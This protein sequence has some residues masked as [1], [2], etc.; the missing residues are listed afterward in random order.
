MTT[1]T[2]TK[3]LTIP[4]REV[5]PGD[6]LFGMT[7]TT[8]KVSSTADELWFIGTESK[9]LWLAPR[10]CFTVERPVPSDPIGTVRAQNEQ[11]IQGRE[12]RVGDEVDYL[13]EWRK[14]AGTGASSLDGAVQIRFEGH[15]LFVYITE[16]GYHDVRRPQTAADLPVGRILR[17]IL[18][19]YYLVKIAENT[20]AQFFS[21]GGLCPRKYSDGDLGTVFDRYEVATF[22]EA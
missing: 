16:S 1:Q 11:T 9:N 14:V 18:E 19:N 21:G 12:I 5:R 10:E 3:S 7:V 2:I 15:D 22:D 4:A 13:D 20:W 8:S 17:H 6:V